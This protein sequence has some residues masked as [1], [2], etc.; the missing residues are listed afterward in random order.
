MLKKQIK[1]KE[2][3][4]G[5]SLG[6]ENTRRKRPQGNVDGGRRVSLWLLEQ[7]EFTVGLSVDYVM[8][9]W[10]EKGPTAE[11]RSC[12]SGC[13]SGCFLPATSTEHCLEEKPT[14]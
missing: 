13:G 7:E 14:H 9:L 1:K 12:G 5:Q 4:Q 8:D 11:G 6:C 2:E 3:E 10:R